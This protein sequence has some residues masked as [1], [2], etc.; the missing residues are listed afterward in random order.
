[1]G[2]MVILQYLHEQQDQDKTGKSVIGTSLPEKGSAE[3]HK[4]PDAHVNHCLR[5]IENSVQ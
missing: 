1:M 3:S 5:L 4:T 2:N